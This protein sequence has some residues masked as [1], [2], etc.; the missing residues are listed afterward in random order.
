MIQASQPHEE[1]TDSCQ[2]PVRLPQMSQCP[3]RPGGQDDGAQD[4]Q[5][6]DS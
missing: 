4:P 3:G 5:G 6:I 1:R 2:N